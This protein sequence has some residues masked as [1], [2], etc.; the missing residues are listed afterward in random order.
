MQIVIPDPEAMET[1]GGELA[2]AILPGMQIHLSGEL[3]S[4]KTTLVRGF[5]RGLGHEGKVK[6]PT[7]TLVE[8]YRPGQVTVYH[9][10]F[11][12]VRH[13]TEL[14]TMGYRD[15]PGVDT[16]CLI[17][18]PEKA[19]GQ[20]GRPDLLIKFQIHADRRKLD[21]AACT[22]RGNLLIS[23]ISARQPDKI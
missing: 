23:K 11:Y 16:I 19:E 7:Y 14:E 18:W 6:S 12:R 22:E 9:F 8:P 10:D 21:L 13:P 4:G 2:L 3:G 1:L 17:E 20:L 5:L 15:Y